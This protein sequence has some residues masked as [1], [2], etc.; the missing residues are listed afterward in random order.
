MDTKMK[1]YD[2]IVIGSGQ[3]G[4]PLVFSMASKGK[5][6]AFIEKTQVGGTCL[7]VGCTPTKTYVA[8]ARRMWDIAHSKDVGVDFEGDFKANML[9]I[10]KR[11]DELISKSR[12]GINKGI[13]K[14]ENVHFFKG[15]AHFVSDKVVEVNNEHMT[16]EQIFINVGGSAFVPEEYKDIPHLTNVSI[17]NLEELPKHLVVVG[18]SYIG[19]EFAQIFKRFGSK[20]TVIEQGENIIGREDQDTS[21]E[22]LE[23]LQ[24][25]GIEFIFNAKKIVPSSDG[26]EVSL[27]INDVTNIS[28]S[29]LLLAIG[30]KPNTEVVKIENTSISVDKKGFI[31]V[32]D[33]C[34]TN[35]KGIFAMGDCNGKGA[36]THTAFNDYQIVENQLFG[37]KSKK[38]SDRIPTYGL[39]VD[40][41]LGRCGMTK[42]EALKKGITVLEGK[43]K[44]ARISRAKEKA[45]TY[46]F[47]SIL[48]DAD[49][50]QIIGAS[51]LGTGGDEIVTSILNV[52]YAKQSYKLIRDSV[53][54]HP[55]ISELIPTTLEKLKEI[56]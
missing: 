45:E 20:V 56:E 4:T 27:L 5:K 24:E 16:A 37:D 18:G 39:F 21:E 51:V 10:K 19:L 26:D 11:K 25:E 15:E 12:K 6:V 28:G 23:F 40:P 9:A 44:M 22:I 50:E 46:G 31:N 30:R 41:P 47:M 1:T 29:H 55:T 3:A 17:L 13:E 35:V 32:D 14:N 42:A 52:M 43:K 54:L 49:S 53:V 7:N 2:A 38:I 34:E 36:F 48:V 33:H 8:S